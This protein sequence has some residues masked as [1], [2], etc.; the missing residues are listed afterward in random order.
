MLKENT[1]WGIR[2]KVKIAIERLK[3]FEPKEGYYL[4]FSGGKDSV[5]IKK[6]ADMAKVKYDAHYNLTTIDPPELIYFIRNQHPDVITDRPKRP[7]LVEMVKR[8]FPRRQSRWCC[9]TYKECG[10]IG[11]FVITGVRR[12]E[13][14]NRKNRRVVEHCYRHKT[15]KLL[16]VIVDWEDS[17]VW[18]FIRKYEIPYCCLYNEG[19]KRIGCLF[20]PFASR[21]IPLEVKR[22]PKY[23]KAFIRAFEKLYQQRKRNGSKSVDRWGNGAEMF[24]W[25]IS[26]K[27]GI[28]PEQ[29]VLFE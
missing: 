8:G 12:A 17:D 26:G 6:L 3:S 10:G 14:N 7:F 2:D 5:V 24:E 20:C 11:R 22:Y 23:M 18:E 13:S 25:Y 16:N 28:R 4:A 1:L 29:H 19:W 15:K 27:G 21:T 9:Q